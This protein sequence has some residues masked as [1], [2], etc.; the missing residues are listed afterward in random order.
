MTTDFDFDPFACEATLPGLVAL[1]R[2]VAQLFIWKKKPFDP[3]HAYAD[4]YLLANTADGKFLTK[5]NTVVEFHPG[6]VCWTL[7]GL[8]DRWGWKRHAVSQFIKRLEESKMIKLHVIDQYSS[9][10]E[11]LQFSTQ[12]ASEPTPNRQ[13]TASEPPAKGTP[14]ATEYGVGVGIYGI[15][16]GEPPS[17]GVSLADATEWFNRQHSGYTDSEI[18]TAYDSFN[19]T[20]VKGVW[21]QVRGSARI[22]V[23][24]WRSAMSVELAT[25]R[26]LFGEKNAAPGG[27]G[28]VAGGVPV[29]IFQKKLSLAEM[30]QDHG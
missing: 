9:A 29:P 6:W 27:N 30:R 11:L 2:A 8:A 24:D 15:G 26:S 25:R 19:A 4:L 10:V 22:P 14:T 18:K 16:G 28:S 23:T 1:P 13:R 21:F 20:A 5:R 12:T 17:N 3:G 7:S